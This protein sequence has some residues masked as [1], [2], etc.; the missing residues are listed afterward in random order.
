[1]KDGPRWAINPEVNNN[2][3]KN[4]SPI[5][6]PEQQENLKIYIKEL[7]RELGQHKP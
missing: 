5:P 1:M 7:E 4:I 6:T 3:E 2:A